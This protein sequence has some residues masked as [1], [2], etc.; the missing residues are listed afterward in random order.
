MGKYS[1]LA[2][3]IVAHVG[4]KQNVSSLR[5]CVTRLRFVLKDESKADTVYLKQRE[6]IITVVKGG[7]E[8]MVVIGNHVHDVFEEVSEVLGL[9]NGSSTPPSDAKKKNILQRALGIVMGAMGP[10][11]HILCA[12]GILKGVLTIVAMAGA[13]TNSG[14]YLL[15]SAIA[16]A[17]F[18]FM[19]LLLGYNLAKKLDIDPA[20]GFI[21][22]ASMIY[23]SIQGV[24]LDLFGFTVN[25]TYTSTF[26]PVIFV[27]AL[28]APLYKFLKKI[29]PSAVNTFMVPALTLVLIVP[30]GFAFVG[31]FAN[32]VG[33]SISIVINVIFGI[34]PVIAGLLVGGLWQILVL[35]GV[36]GMLV[37]FAFMDL[38]QGN[39]VQ[40]LTFMSSSC[41][42]QVGVVLA[43]YLKTK[44]KKLKDIALPAIFS[45]I[46]GVTEP[47]IYGVTLP[48]IKMFAISCVGGAIG[49][50]IAGI[51]GLV[52]Y[53]YTGMGIVGLMGMIDPN[54]GTNF[55]GIALIVIVPF[56]FTFIT[57]SLTY[58]DEDGAETSS[59]IPKKAVK[60]M[61]E[62]SAQNEKTAKSFTISSPVSGTVTPLDSCSDEAFASEVLGKGAVIL[63]TEGVIRAPFDGTVETLFHTNH[64]IALTSDNG[65]HVLIH[66]G[67]NTVRLNGEGFAACVKQNDSVKKGQELIRFDRESIQAKGYD[68]SI[69]VIVTNADDFAD[70]IELTNE[71]IN[72]GAPLLTVIN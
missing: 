12:S 72:A 30:I 1:E 51:S 50:L 28:A 44:D 62:Q 40:M 27:V 14:L 4:G 53:N 71:S 43:I 7:G 39:P 3:D 13:D 32:L 23:P 20:L 63:P 21:I 38:L 24:D 59:I 42:A 52:M 33:R 69:P 64:A 37:M 47:A 5:H 70:V 56:L 66:I 35:F 17:F 45:G 22:G 49:G 10:N 48:R 67:L 55:L 60:K 2:K 16:D 61:E 8:Y 25:T 68:T 65:C 19:P 29:I 26:F 58:K 57:A 15:M 41:W 36:H 6:G 18:H 11:L 54:G 31:P 9:S 46:F 34:S